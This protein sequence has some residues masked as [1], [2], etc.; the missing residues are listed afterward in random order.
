MVLALAG[1]EEVGEGV[2]GQGAA[3]D[4][5][6]AAAV[7]PRESPRRREVHRCPRVPLCGVRAAPLPHARRHH[8]VHVDG[9]RADRGRLGGRC[10][11]R[12]AHRVDHRLHA[13]GGQREKV[14]CT[15]R[16]LLRKHGAH[17]ALC[18]G[19]GG[20]G[21]PRRLHSQRRRRQLG[22]HALHQVQHE[23]AQPRGVPVRSVRCP[24]PEL[25]LADGAPSLLPLLPLSPLCPLPVHV[26]RQHIPCGRGRRTGVSACL[27]R[28]LPS[29]P[30]PPPPRT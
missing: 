15:G 7:V 14:P 3:V 12:L 21:Q 20:P 8:L 1:E 10:P 28:P 17:R 24:R 13:R 26:R 9:P 27:L 16:V 30:P 5:G 4:E 2:K 11:R 19:H 18:S 23:H 22:H 25:R 29:P 6:G